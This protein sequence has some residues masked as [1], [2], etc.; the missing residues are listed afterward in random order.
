MHL[1]MWD[2]KGSALHMHPLITQLRDK[3]IPL[4]AKPVGFQIFDGWTCVYES[5]SML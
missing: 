1:Y 2:A 4:T 5:L 3:G